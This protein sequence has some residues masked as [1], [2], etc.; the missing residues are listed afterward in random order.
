MV[1][2]LVAGGLIGLVVG[3]L[4]GAARGG[5]WFGLAYGLLAAGIVWSASS[6][7][8]GNRADGMAGISNLV[9]GGVLLWLLVVPAAVA[10]LLMEYRKR[11]SGPRSV[12]Q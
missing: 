8:A 9:L 5:K 6:I 7:I 11:R 12:G 4:L 1:T 2:V 3:A 10:C